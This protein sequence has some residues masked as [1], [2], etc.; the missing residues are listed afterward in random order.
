M[1]VSHHNREQNYKK[2]GKGQLRYFNLYDNP[3][4][5]SNGEVS[6]FRGDIL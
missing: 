3:K 4:C 5:V 6:S 1:P 2:D